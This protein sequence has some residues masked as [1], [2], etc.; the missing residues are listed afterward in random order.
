M[1]P[2]VQW[3]GQVKVLMDWQT[4]V[5]SQ[6]L[7]LISTTQ[8]TTDGLMWA[9]LFVFRIWNQNTVKANGAISVLVT[10]ELWTSEMRCL[11]NFFRFKLI[12]THI[13]LQ[14]NVVS[15]THN[16]HAKFETIMKCTVLCVMCI[17]CDNLLIARM[18]F[19]LEHDGFFPFSL[20]LYLSLSPYGLLSKKLKRKPPNLATHSIKSRTYTAAVIS[21]I[22]L[23]FVTVIKH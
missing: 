22:F 15:K 23:F 18:K 12:Y 11:M 9:C 13:L 3:F 17:C 16:F 19:D 8:Q 1:S 4:F 5:L 21:T 14:T 10:E 6:F 2:F 7:S 20:S